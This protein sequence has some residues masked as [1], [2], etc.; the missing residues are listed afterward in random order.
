MRKDPAVAKPIADFIF[1]AAD[2]LG[3][4]NGDI[5]SDLYWQ[6]LAFQHGGL[7][8]MHKLAD[9]RKLT[10][11][12]L[13]AWSSIANGMEKKNADLITA[14]NLALL[15]H[16][17]Q[18]ILQKNVFDSWKAQIAGKYLAEL[19]KSPFPMGTSFSK[20]KPRGN[21]ANFDD[22]WDWL[23]NKFWVEWEEYRKDHPDLAKPDN[24]ITRKMDYYISEGKRILKPE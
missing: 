16:E 17:Q 3:E 14:G 5:Y 9:D 19:V 15:K 2:K 6:L 4:G 20:Y 1:E 24:P 12:S 13:A 22:R 18:D 11:E 7:P 8:Q 21:Y 23:K 10:K